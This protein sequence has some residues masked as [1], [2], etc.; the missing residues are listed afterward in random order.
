MGN[1]C[2]RADAGDL[3]SAGTILTG[4]DPAGVITLMRAGQYRYASAPSAVTYDGYV[5]AALDFVCD[6]TFSAAAID[7]RA[8]D[9]GPAGAG[10]D[11]GY[12]A[13]QRRN[14]FVFGDWAVA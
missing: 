4:A 3:L 8:A 1:H 12:P 14:A 6:D 9:S 2:R 7:S 10:S 5:W 11:G 13:D